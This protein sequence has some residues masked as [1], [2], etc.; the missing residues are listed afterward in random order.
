MKSF[1][2]EDEQHRILAKADLKSNPDS[3]E[4]SLGTENLPLKL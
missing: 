4:V 3:N 1:F 2:T